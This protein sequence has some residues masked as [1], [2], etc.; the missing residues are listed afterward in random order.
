MLTMGWGTKILAGTFG[1]AMF[2]GTIVLSSGTGA[3]A[4][5]PGGIDLTLVAKITDSIDGYSGDQ[6]INAADI[7]NAAT[8]LSLSTQ[9]QTIG[10]MTAMAQSGLEVLDHGTAADPDARGLFQEPASWGTDD[11]RTDPNASAV[12]FF[13]RLETVPRWGTMTPAAAATAVEQNIPATPY[14][15]DFAAAAAVVDGLANRAGGGACGAHQAS[16]DYP[17]PAAPIGTLSPLGYD[18]RE[19]TD[20]VAWRLNR[21]AGITIV[22]WKYTWEWLTPLGGNA[23]DWKKNW[24]SHGWPTSNIPMPGAVAWWG[25][26]AG[27][28]GHVAYVQAVN[29]SGTITIEEYNWGGTHHYDARTIGAGTP[30]LYLYPPPR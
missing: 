22:P 29:A 11:E 7:M 30:D 23:I 14:D 10:V 4:C 21:D 5:S 26:S 28:D 18:Y 19:C 8:S 2:A 6:L 3:A 16:D 20:F 24:V 15:A 12:L 17:W 1:A 13:S 25:K 9:A 27:A